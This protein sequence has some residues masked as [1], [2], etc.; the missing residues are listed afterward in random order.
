MYLGEVHAV[1]RFR[2]V[3]GFSTPD[4]PPAYQSFSSS[5]HAVLW[6]VGIFGGDVVIWPQP[7][8]RRSIG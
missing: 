4:F 2:C 7:E 1:S 5:P 3:H 8:A 6:T